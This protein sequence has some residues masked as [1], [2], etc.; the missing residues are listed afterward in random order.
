MQRKP[1]R[2]YAH[3]SKGGYAIL[4]I[5][6]D[7]NLLM[8]SSINVEEPG[9]YKILKNSWNNNHGGLSIDDLYV[10]REQRPYLEKLRNTY[11][12][13]VKTYVYGEWKI[14][15]YFKEVIEQKTVCQRCGAKIKHAYTISNLSNKNKMIVGS[16]CINNF[17][18]SKQ[19]K[20]EVYNRIKEKIPNYEDIKEELRQFYINKKYPFPASITNRSKASYRKILAIENKLTIDNLNSVDELLKELT[21]E[22]VPGAL[23]I[24]NEIIAYH[25]KNLSKEFYCNEV[26]YEEISGEPQ[27]VK[28]VE[29]N[30]SFITPSIA[31][32]IKSTVFYNSYGNVIEEKL[33]IKSLRINRDVT[34]FV[35]RGLKVEAKNSM[36]L[37]IANEIIFSK[38]NCNKKFQQLKIKI[39]M[40]SLFN[41]FENTVYEYKA[42][43]IGFIKKNFVFEEN[44]HG[45]FIKKS[46]LYLEYSEKVIGD[47]RISDV[48]FTEKMIEK[49]ESFLAKV[50]KSEWKTMEEIQELKELMEENPSRNKD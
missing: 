24:K 10:K 27:K 2:V 42:N 7:M 35:I 31:T 49:V 22:V 38:S 9:I 37:K 43:S 48:L 23:S 33:N 44:E 41:D 17:I 26:I 15:S 12:L 36:F 14:H 5:K 8:K 39:S 25:N 4:I 13:I 28:M 6:K 1:I 45:Y 50:P 30:D 11:K 29:S 19:M 18:D 32:M 21:D 16:E 34:V 20:I 40:A 46:N 47:F 3:E